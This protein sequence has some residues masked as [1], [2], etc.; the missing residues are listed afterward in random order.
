MSPLDS[1]FHR[2]FVRALTNCLRQKRSAIA[3]ESRLHEVIKEALTSMGVS[4]EHEHALSKD[5]II[6]FLLPYGVGIEVK[7]S[8]ISAPVLLRQVG[9]YMQHEKVTSCI[10]IANRVEGMPSEYLGKP[11]ATIELWRLLL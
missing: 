4:F 8:G 7:K 2:L 1:T 11:V 5:D 10:V 6:D 3:D 9:R